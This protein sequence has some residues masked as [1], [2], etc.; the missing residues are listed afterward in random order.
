[1]GEQVPGM[2]FKKDMSFQLR[3]DGYFASYNRPSF[4]KIREVSGHTAAE[5]KYGALYS[6]AAGPR[7]AIFKNVA[8]MTEHLMDMRSTMNRNAYPGEGVLPSS[9][10][11][12][13]KQLT[14]DSPRVDSAMLKSCKLML[15]VPLLV[16]GSKLGK[17]EVPPENLVDCGVYGIQEKE[18]SDIGCCWR[19]GQPNSLPPWCFYP[20][21]QSPVPKGSILLTYL[22]DE[23]GAE[24]QMLDM[25]WTFAGG[26]VIHT[27][28][29]PG[30][31]TEAIVAQSKALA[32]LQTKN[33]L[34]CGHCL[35]I[36]YWASLHHVPIVPINIA[37]GGYDFS[38]AKKFLLN[39]DRFPKSPPSMVF[40]ANGIDLV[41][42]A[43]RLGTE[44]PYIIS[45]DF[46]GTGSRGGSNSDP[47]R[48]I[49]NVINKCAPSYGPGL[50][51]IGTFKVWRDDVANNVTQSSSLPHQPDSRHFDV[52]LSNYIKEGGKAGRLLKMLLLAQENNGINSIF[53]D[54]H[55]LRDMR[56]E[57]TNVLQSKMLLVIATRD[58]FTR[59][60]CLLETYFALLNQSRVALIDVI[61][62]GFE[63]ERAHQFLATLDQSL[64]VANPG[65]TATLVEN[66]LSISEVQRVLLEKF[67]Q[68]EVLPFF[69]AADAETLKGQV[70]AIART[71]NGNGT[72][73]IV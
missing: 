40:R 13:S 3:N 66:G 59:P 16:G 67:E 31:I 44:L 10:L 14:T 51:D 68:L 63:R 70:D 9:I 34:E 21:P 5:A 20:K 64:E 72:A 52:Y 15:L 39:M 62:E 29:R 61:G 58:F 6:Y 69:G 53:L 7:A 33:I 65:A 27:A 46:D 41:T 22:R 60:Y 4:P 55:D 17:C 1:M 30:Y 49:F 24:A 23:A 47:Q 56:Q 38:S 57:A 43:W 32:L 37:K 50:S 18:C 12:D 11:R 54:V 19:G 26:T 35:L 45:E 36:A 71:I 25:G 2:M 28:E 73:A 42:A 8:P 48:Y